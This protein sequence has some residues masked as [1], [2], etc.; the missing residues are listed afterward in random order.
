M[1]WVQSDFQLKFFLDESLAKRDNKG[2]SLIK[3]FI[4]I[5]YLKLGKAKKNDAE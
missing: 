5:I 2:I 3:K 1:Y 4:R